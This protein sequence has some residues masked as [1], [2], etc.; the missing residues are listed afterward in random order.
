VGDIVAF[1]KAVEA[2][3]PPLNKAYKLGLQ[4]LKKHSK[5]VQCP[6]HSVTGS[7]DIDSAMEKEPQHA[8]ANR[9]D[10]GIGYKPA[11]GRECAVWIEVHGAND[12]E[13]GTLT[14]KVKWLKEYLKR[15]APQLWALTLLSPEENRYVWLGTKDVHLSMS[16]PAYRRA[17]QEGVTLHGTVLKLS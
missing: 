9:W 6:A 3:E 14:R 12:Q 13:V 8:S 7:I 1:K 4:A 15:H 10:Y 17:A 2:A 11:K 16:D 5:K